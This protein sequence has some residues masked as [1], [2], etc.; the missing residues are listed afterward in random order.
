MGT[1]FTVFSSGKMARGALFFFS[2]THNLQSQF[3]AV[4]LA[5]L[6]LIK[7]FLCGY[8]YLGFSKYNISG[9]LL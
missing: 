7:L 3:K 6:P 9:L 1:V 2:C 5:G 8:N 4:V